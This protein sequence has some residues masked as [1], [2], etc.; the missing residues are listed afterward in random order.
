MV[1][2]LHPVFLRGLVIRQRTFVI[3][4]PFN[5]GRIGQTPVNSLMGITGDIFHLSVAFYLCGQSADRVLTEC[6][7]SA[8][9][10][11]VKC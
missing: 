7:Q 3:I 8:D 6:G 4:L 10:V 9:R 1:L 5:T 11:L 2:P